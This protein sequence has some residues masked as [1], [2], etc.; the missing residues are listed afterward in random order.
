MSN[1]W[2]S[3]LN[4]KD[5]LLGFFHRNNPRFWRFGLQSIPVLSYPPIDNATVLFFNGRDVTHGWI[6]FP[7]SWPNVQQQDNATIY[8]YIGIYIYR[9]IY[10]HINVYCIALYYIKLSHI[11]YLISYILYYIILYHI[12][13]YYII[14]CILPFLYFYGICS[15]L[16]IVCLFF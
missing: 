1:S 7:V 9:H 2:N 10:I 3:C 8:V 14:H 5:H 11:S 6:R 4:L 12:T 16:Y 15:I 13:L